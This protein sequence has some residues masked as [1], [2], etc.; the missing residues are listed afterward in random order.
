MFGR[1]LVAAHGA[2]PSDV[3]ALVAAIERASYADD[4]RGAGGADLSGAVRSAR[5][6]LRAYAPRARRLL[7]Q[8]VPRSLVVRPGSAYAHPPE[9]AAAR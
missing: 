8:L 7:G 4:G 2:S 3:D 9:P 6:S 1:R 5:D